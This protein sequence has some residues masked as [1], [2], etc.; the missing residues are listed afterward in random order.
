MS[1][2]RLL[3]IEI[4]DL[5]VTAA[6]WSNSAA[7]L[8]PLGMDTPEL[9]GFARLSGKGEVVFGR[10]AFEQFLTSENA[11]DNLYWHRLATTGK[12]PSLRRRRRSQPSDTE[13]AQAHLT[14]VMDNCRKLGGVSSE[15]VLA[16]PGHFKP[17]NLG[18]LIA[19]SEAIGIRV[20]HILDSS[21]ASLLTLPVVPDRKSFV[22]M[23]MHW[24]TTEVARIVSTESGL[25]RHV[26]TEDR[27]ALGLRQIL[28]RLVTGLAQRFIDQFRFDPAARPEHAQEL[29]NQLSAY[30]SNPK[31]IAVCT[32]RTPK[33]SISID[34][35]DLAKWIDKELRGLSE[36]AGDAIG[37][38]NDP[39]DCAVFLSSRIHRIPG[40]MELLRKDHG[41]NPRVME[42]GQ[43]AQGALAFR[44]ALGGDFATDQ[45]LFHTE[46]K[47]QVNKEQPSE[48][49]SIPPGKVYHSGKDGILGPTYP[50]HLL[51][52]GRLLKLPEFGAMDFTIGKGKSIAS[53]LTVVEPVKGLADSHALLHRRKDGGIELTGAKGKQTWLNGESITSNGAVALQVGDVITLGAPIMQ[54]MI[55]GMAKSDA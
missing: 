47:F 49:G 1:D 8:L 45:P 42:I 3:G 12:D 44:N 35:G 15:V 14:A 16:V 43:A 39:R 25:E 34:G 27:R 37:L 6:R 30:L 4:S 54:V 28:D 10:S 17:S 11:L 23:D 51:F 40:L 38:A 26:V 33:G 21:L 41:V 18:R 22:V 31:E 24:N 2:K 46:V 9:S 53:G 20:E 29:Y 36:L 48:P 32:I 7:Q 5:G 52:Q 50:T 19:V 13:L 55:V